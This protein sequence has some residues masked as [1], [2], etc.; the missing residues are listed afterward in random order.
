MACE[1]NSILNKLRERQDSKID[2]QA[3]KRAVAWRNSYTD[4]DTQKGRQAPRRNARV[5]VENLFDLQKLIA[6]AKQ[7]RLKTKSQINDTNSHISSDS[8]TSTTS[9]DS[10]D[11]LSRSSGS[12]AT[13]DNDSVSSH[14]CTTS[15]DDDAEEDN[16]DGDISY[17]NRDCT[18]STSDDT[19]SDN[20]SA[21]S[22][23]A[24]NVSNSG[25]MVSVD[26]AERQ[27]NTSTAKVTGH[28][29]AHFKSLVR[30]NNLR[31]QE[32]LPRRH[33]RM[34]KTSAVLAKEAHLLDQHTTNSSG[35]QEQTG[36]RVL[37]I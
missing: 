9:S 33:A 35:I 7:K 1:R 20:G 15:D 12:G 14:S 28:K 19:T 17:S 26:A 4:D 8:A 2:N 6:A 34:I 32:T 22:C 10:G 16:S 36:I 21:S 18:S 23:H 25:Q 29:L 31:L 30:R 13:A 37:Y 27:Q 11:E 3:G 24:D 5:L